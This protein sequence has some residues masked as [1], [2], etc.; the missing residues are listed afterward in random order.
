MSHSIPLRAVCY[1]CTCTCTH[2]HTHTRSSLSDLVPLAFLQ[3]S[4]HTMA[5][6]ACMRQPYH[7]V[8]AARCYESSR[9]IVFLNL[10]YKCTFSF[11]ISF[12][13]SSISRSSFSC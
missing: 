4:F 11:C 1:P 3:Q 10:P 9:L 2:T 5:R 12:L 13:M 7:P 6:V 8:H